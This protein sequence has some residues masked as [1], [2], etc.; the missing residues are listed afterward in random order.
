MSSITTA[1]EALEATGREP[2]RASGDES[3]KPVAVKRPRLYVL[4]GLRLIAAMGV[5]AWHWLGVERFP[6]VWHGLPSKLMPLG[7]LIGAYSWTGVELFFLISGFV[8]C[9]S[10]WGRSLGDFVTSRVVR[11]FPAYW[12]CVLI[13][14]V[15]LLIVPTI[16]GDN[17]HRPDPS[18]ILSNLSMANAPLGVDN[19]DPVYWTLWSELRFY[20]LFGFMVA[21]GLTYRRVLAFCGIWAFVS[22]LAMQANMPLLT[23]IVQPTYAWYFIGGIT[24]YLMYRFGQNLMLWGMLG[25]CWLIAQD[26][27]RG[28]IGGYEYGTHHHLSWWI[29]EGFTT[30][31]FV[32]V[33][34]AAL[35][36]FNWMRWK[37]LTVAGALTY[38]L[39]LLHQEIGW[40]LITRLRA[41]HLAPYP[42]LAVVTVVMLFAAWLVHRL[43]ERPL[44][45]LMKRKMDAAFAQ[46]RLDGLRPDGKAGPGRNR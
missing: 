44:A 12:V 35:G 13:T 1:S 42:T 2:V 15:T 20:V 24:I 36:A 39:Y 5:V 33:T 16:W 14:A 25:F 34:A 37:W 18:R 27:I 21:I 26:Q 10:C 29:T 3:A 45:P 32:V 31:A 17:T 9:M 23:A 41:H 6:A 38:P 19:L 11:L 22:L 46:V 30:G 43:V 4:D 40:Q 7:H 8:I 28:V